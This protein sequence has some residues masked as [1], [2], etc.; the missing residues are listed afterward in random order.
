MEDAADVLEEAADEV[1]A[2]DEA[3]DELADD[4]A[5]E[6]F[7]DA[8]DEADDAA[9]E[10]F[11]DEVAALLV[12]V[13]DAGAEELDVPDPDFPAQPVIASVNTAAAQSI[14]AK[15]LCDLLIFSPF[16]LHGLSIII[17]AFVSSF[18][19]KSAYIV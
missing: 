9:E 16:C 17:P 2:E 8:A 19:T 10:V 1:F 12:D 5:E 14:E 3:D 15:S 18:K 4:A 11:A 13:C 7:E 6:V